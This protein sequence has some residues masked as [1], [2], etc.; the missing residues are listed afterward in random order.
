MIYDKVYV[1]VF[2]CVHE[3]EDVERKRKDRSYFTA[4]KHWLNMAKLRNTR[5]QFTLYNYST[6]TMKN[7]FPF[8]M[9]ILLF[10]LLSFTTCGRANDI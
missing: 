4:Q 8:K 5:M 1:R 2:M 6:N 10:K 7:Y 3:G 9:F